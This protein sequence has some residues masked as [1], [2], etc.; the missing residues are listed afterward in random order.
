MI[1]KNKTLNITGDKMQTGDFKFIR[2]LNGQLVLN[3]IRKHSV[4]SSS[5]LVN[6]SGLRPSTI[7]NILKDFSD[8]GFI[9]NLGKGD[10][11]DKGGKKP[12]LW[13][14]NKSAAF[15]LG[16]DIEINAMTIVLLDLNGEMLQRDYVRFEKLKSEEELVNII[17]SSVRGFLD[18]SKIDNDKILGMG[19]A[20]PG[21]VNYEKGFI[22]RNDVLPERNIPLAE[23]LEQFYKFPVLIDNNANATALGSKWVG[24]G[25]D[26]KNFLVVL[27]EFDKNIGGMGV[28]IVIDGYLYN[29][30]NHCAGELNIPLS[31]LDQMMIFIRNE[32]D[33]SNILSKYDSDVDGL[34]VEVLIAAAKQGDPIALSLFKR[35]GFQIGEIIHQ[36]ISLLN[37]EALIVAGTISDLN[38]IIIEPIKE[39]VKTR[40]LPFTFEK[41]QIATSV[42]GVNA[43][44]IGAASL[45]LNEFFKMPIIKKYSYPENLAIHAE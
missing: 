3:L 5:E 36:S 28:G 2:T 25:K 17:N 15:V 31:N 19:I 30:F 4:I 41:L 35:L 40:T 43:V 22:I 10:S 11:S 32:L 1:K 42:H 9:N 16:L 20:V 14:I 8:K 44:A 39:V 26:F 6:L 45:V 21:I 27:I 7:F 13:E 38:E 34:T 24:I 23:K 12:F 37:A 29:G 33:K 18:S